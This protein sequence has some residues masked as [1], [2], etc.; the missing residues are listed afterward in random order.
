MSEIKVSKENDFAAVIAGASGV[1]RGAVEAVL[2][3]LEAAGWIIGRT[4]G[5]EAPVFG[6]RQEAEARDAGHDAG[7]QIGYSKGR[8]EER[9]A[10]LAHLRAKDA[11]EHAPMLFELVRDLENGRHEQGRKR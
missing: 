11:P 8:S 1:P 3:A 2:K 7:A 4:I 10:V 9:A 6:M 5:P